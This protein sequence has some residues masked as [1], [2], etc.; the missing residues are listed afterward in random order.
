MLHATRQNAKFMKYHEFQANR[1]K[2][3]SQQ[4]SFD[5]SID[6]NVPKNVI[7]LD[8]SQQKFNTVNITDQLSHATLSNFQIQNA[9]GSIFETTMDRK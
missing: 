2:I 6:E 3:S 9:N 7:D 1:K 4:N 5:A 8:F